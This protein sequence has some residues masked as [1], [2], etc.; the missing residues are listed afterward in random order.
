MSPR[1]LAIDLDYLRQVLMELLEIPSP[2]RRDLADFPSLAVQPAGGEG[3]REG[4][5]GIAD[6][7][8][9][10]PHSRPAV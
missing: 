10:A 3:P 8:A 9:A 2:S 6:A 1:P 7:A 4:P 5:I